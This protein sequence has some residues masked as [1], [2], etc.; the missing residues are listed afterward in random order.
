M[1]SS[2]LLPVGS[3]FNLKSSIYDYYNKSEIQK[4]NSN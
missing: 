2:S 4:K 3:M 1:I